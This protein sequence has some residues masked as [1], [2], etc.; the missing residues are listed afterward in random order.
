MPRKSR[1][2]PLGL[3]PFQGE[4][5]K[6]VG[7]EITNASGGLQDPLDIDPEM[8]EQVAKVQIG[9]TRFFLLRSDCVKVRYQPVKG[10]EGSLKYVPIFRCT[11]ATMIDA[12]WAIDAINNQRD[13]ITRLR[14]EAEGITRLPLGEEAGGAAVEES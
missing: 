13:T 10:D 7:V 2:N 5:V 6:A 3:E 11:D 4:P 9:D 1:E 12:E 8:I 14:E